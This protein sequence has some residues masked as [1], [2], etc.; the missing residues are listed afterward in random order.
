[1][2][3]NQILSGKHKQDAQFLAARVSIAASII[4]TIIPTIIGLMTD[5]ITL[6]LDASA[7]MVILAAGFMMHFSIKKIHQPPDEWYNFGYNKYE[8]LTAAI[9]N[10]LIIAVCV[11]SIKFAVQDII[12]SENALSY[13]LPVIGTFCEGLLGIFITVYLKKI[14]LRTD[15]H[16]IK[17]SCSH[18]FIDTMLAFGVCAGFCTGLFMQNLGYAHI[19]PYIDPV[20]AIILAVFFIA[21]PIKGGLISLYELL[22]AMP[23][24]DIRQKVSRIAGGYDPDIF[25]ISLL[26]IRKAGHKI[27]VDAC[28]TVTGESVITRALDMAERFEQDLKAHIPECDVVVRFK[29][30]KKFL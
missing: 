11:V 12:H 27:F 6:I 30:E 10:A 29:S 14:A 17:T 21:T 22:D 23:S 25:D 1:M 2:K 3:Q 24:S 9:Q 16:M 13:G 5:S 26:R 8:P 20:M 28:F 7:S 19:T 18:W 15:S 4:A